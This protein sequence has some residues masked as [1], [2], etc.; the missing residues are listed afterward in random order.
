MPANNRFEL[1]LGAFDSIVERDLP[2]PHQINYEVTRDT[3]RTFAWAI[4]DYNALYL[5]DD[6]ARQTRWGTRIAPPGYLASHGS[7]AWL[8]RHV[9]P[10][11]D[12]EGSTLSELVHASEEWRFLRPVRPGDHV[13][14]HSKIS[15]A[16]AKVGSRVG[17][18]VRVDMLTRYF[19]HRGEDTAVRVDTCFLLNKTKAGAGSVIGY[20][21]IENGATTRNV[22]QPTR[23]PGTF[24]VPGQRAYPQRYFEDVSIG[25]AVTPLHI[26]PV[27]LQNL[28]RFCAA[29]LAS[30]VDETGGPVPGSA[31]PDAYV[32]GHLR[33]PWFGTMITA[34]GGPGTWIQRLAQRDRSW[35]LIGFSVDCR[36]SVVA[37]SGDP[38]D[39][40]I[41]LALECVNELGHVTNVGTSRVTLPV[42]Q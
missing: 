32:F 18:S 36:G 8:A 6:Y 42:R 16:E 2:Q 41:D 19:N 14:S 25:D 12:E 37:K 28:A 3:I 20:P 40:W 34:W 5:D 1:D 22:I 26:P 13:L 7:S 11:V 33:V 4:D 30:G 35:L 27:M 31:L 24:S 38:S 10:V 39:P 29:T 17:A 21:P 15:R 23:F 9:P